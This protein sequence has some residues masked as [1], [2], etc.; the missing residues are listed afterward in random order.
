MKTLF[1]V[2]AVLK[3]VRA[4]NAEHGMFRPGDRV[5]V[6]VSGGVDS[7][8]LVDILVSLN[9][10]RLDLVVAHLNHKLR[11]A[12][13]DEDERFVEQCA[14]AYALPFVSRGEQVK[15]LAERERLSLEDAGRRA[16]YAFFD[17]VAAVCGAR[18]VALA[19][20]ADD[21][22]ETLLMRLV[23]GAGGLGLSA[24]QPVGAGGKYVR[25]LLALGRQEI[26]A[27]LD[28]RGLA[29]RQD[30]TNSDLAF[31]RNRIRHELVPYLDRLN[32]GA[33]SR[34]ARTAELLADD[35]ALL[36]RLVEEASTRHV[37][38]TEQ[39]GAICSVDTLR[40]EP[41]GLRRRLYRKAIALA[42][43][44]LARI[45]FDHVD[46]ID[47]LV[48]S[49][50]PSGRLHLPEEIL[51]TRSYNEVA[52]ARRIADIPSLQELWIDGP[53][54]WPLSGGGELV[55]EIATGPPPWGELPT[56]ES[57]FDLERAPFPWLVRGWRPGDRM[58]PLGM[59]GEKK[60]KDIFIDQKVP[61]E[62]RRSIPLLF[63]GDSLLWVCGCRRGEPAR[64]TAGSRAMAVVQIR[65]RRLK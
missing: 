13:S 30:Q 41:R 49:E 26:E 58:I 5:V 9:E 56:T 11:G 34:L 46:A 57:W 59:T 18:T 40:S 17:D 50:N 63:R 20:H 32:P 21:Q 4:F 6:A 31:L 37:M 23:R 28:A 64:I 19:H 62:L 8:A 54:C 51:V 22:A 35:E 12:A 52:F 24:M 15:A 16:R 48:L 61:R 2:D 33:A 53:G 1:P 10:L 38:V 60:V 25:P 45:S 14:Q 3:K 43:G 27:Y 39:G 55:I 65:G 47:R 44:D 7:V 42:K 36:S 29:F